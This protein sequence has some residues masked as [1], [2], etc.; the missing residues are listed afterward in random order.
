MRGDSLETCNEYYLAREMADWL[1]NSR[2][3]RAKPVG[4]WDSGMSNDTG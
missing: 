2:K 4:G 3:K 1:H